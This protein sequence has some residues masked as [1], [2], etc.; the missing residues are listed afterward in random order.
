VAKRS[1]FVKI[2][3]AAASVVLSLAGGAATAA[4][5]RAVDVPTGVTAGIAVFDRATGQSTLT[6]NPHKQFRSASLVKIL[7]ALD[8]LETRGP[9]AEIPA[10]DLARLQPM[11]RSSHDLAASELWVLNGW[12]KIVERMVAK[13]DLADTQ[14]P[15]DR[16]FWGYT[17]ISAADMVKIY[18]YILETAHPKIR[19][20]IMSN[21][22]QSTKC[23]S[24]GFDQSFGIPSAV[25][26][27]R[28]VKQ[29][30]SRFGN[31][32]PRPC[33]AEQTGG[34]T[35]GM[36]VSASQDAPADQVRSL[37]GAAPDIDLTS[38]AM[39]TSGAVGADDSKIIVVLT[40]EPEGTSW[41]DSAER[42]T[43]LT[44]AVHLVTGDNRG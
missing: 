40:L 5:A 30:W 1:T 9:D 28:A 21:L 10:E 33:V 6:Y 12:E 42:L 4:T 37:A 7:I 16:R 31:T 36:K 15:A 35:P 20:F 22:H 3:L 14:P 39:H 11:L 2:V 26:P 13:L 32:P 44:K 8:Y 43:V 25:A 27:P 41:D 18:R 29:G 19:D 38:P 23:A 34:G 24:D 17:A